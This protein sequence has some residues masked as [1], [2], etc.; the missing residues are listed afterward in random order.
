MVF[1]GPSAHGDHHGR[2]VD[3]GD[4]PQRLGDVHGRLLEHVHV[5]GDRVPAGD[6]DRVAVG[7]GACDELGRDIAERARLVLDDD[8]AAHQRAHLVGEVPHDDVGAAAGREAADEVHVLRRVGLRPA[9]CGGV[10]RCGKRS[11]SR[12]A[13]LVPASWRSPIRR[14]LN[15]STATRGSVRPPRQLDILLRDRIDKFGGEPHGLSACGITSP[16]GPP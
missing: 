6:Q 9:A 13:S 12:A 1:H 3:G 15:L 2:V 5:G 16:R 14:Q 8:G 4:D 10:D 11:R 7:L